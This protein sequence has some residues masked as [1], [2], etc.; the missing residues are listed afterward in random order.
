M[1][2]YKQILPKDILMDDLKNLVAAEIWEIDPQRA[3]IC[4]L[5][6]SGLVDTEAYLKNNPDVAKS[7]ICPIYHY[8]MHGYAEKR[9]L[10]KKCPCSGETTPRQAQ[11]A[12]THR[13]EEIGL[14]ELRDENRLLLKQLHEAQEELEKYQRARSHA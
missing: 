1:L 7:G 12:E 11:A 5:R 4:A 10:E 2:D 9:K 14:E 13:E 3:L 8:V 6:R